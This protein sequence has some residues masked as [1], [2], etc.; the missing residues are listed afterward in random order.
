[1]SGP[2]YV[3]KQYQCAI[4]AQNMDRRH[5]NLYLFIIFFFIYCQSSSQVTETNNELWVKPNNG[6]R[7]KTKRKKQQGYKSKY[8]IIV[9]IVKVRSME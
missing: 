3:W 8:I 2:Y 1:M 5:C 4:S 9:V 6:Y 7:N